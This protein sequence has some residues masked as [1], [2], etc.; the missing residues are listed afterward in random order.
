MESWALCYA[1]HYFVVATPVVGMKEGAGTTDTVNESEHVEGVSNG[2]RSSTKIFWLTDPQF[3]WH[4]IPQLLKTKS[5]P[6]KS[7]SPPP[8]PSPRVVFSVDS[9][10]SLIALKEMCNGQ[11]VSTVHNPLDGGS[12][13]DAAADAEG[14]HTNTTTRNNHNH[15]CMCSTGNVRIISILLLQCN[16]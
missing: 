11:G 1:C 9:I 10:A 13:S 6:E 4:L 16:E 14:T 5:V 8:P 15:S 3:S 7:S 12:P 2:R